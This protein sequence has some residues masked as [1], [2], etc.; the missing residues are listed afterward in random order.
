MSREGDTQIGGFWG[1][2]PLKQPGKGRTTQGHRANFRHLLRQLDNGEPNKES[3][4]TMISLAPIST[5]LLISTS[6]S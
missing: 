1:G 5:W 6:Q 4:K 2:F 3:V